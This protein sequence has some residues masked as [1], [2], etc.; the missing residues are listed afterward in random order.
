MD[1]LL[2]WVVGLALLAALVF[3][4]FLLITR[5]T[6][7]ILGPRRRLEEELGLEALR[8]RRRASR[9]PYRAVTPAT[10]RRRSDP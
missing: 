1:Y 9:P 10:P 7:A 3:G 6:R 5:G 4:L 2:A 8:S